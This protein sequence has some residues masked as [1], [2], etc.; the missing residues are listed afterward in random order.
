MYNKYKAYNSK[1][2]KYIDQ[3][4]QKQTV[5]PAKGTR[6][7]VNLLI[8]MPADRWAKTTWMSTGQIWNLYHHTK[9]SSIIFEYNWYNG[10][11]IL[12]CNNTYNIKYYIYNTQQCILC[13]PYHLQERR[14]HQSHC[15]RQAT[16]GGRAFKSHSMKLKQ[17]P[18]KFIW[19]HRENGIY[20]QRASVPLPD[21][22]IIKSIKTAMQASASNQCVYDVTSD[23]YNTSK[24]NTKT[25]I[26]DIIDIIDIISISDI[27]KKCYPPWLAPIY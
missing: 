22:S 18:G 13:S 5:N 6:T 14:A 25:S 8:R 16:A 21:L 10:Y 7:Q 3:S 17:K 19:Q 23:L 1:K 27:I 26:N 9:E 15:G 20:N 4:I 24:S 11:N 2:L 12:K